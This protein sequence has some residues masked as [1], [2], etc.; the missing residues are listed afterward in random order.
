MKGVFRRYIA[1]YADSHQSVLNCAMHFIGIPTLFVAVLIP[2]GLYPVNIGP[3][4]IS[5]GSLM[6]VPAAIGWIALEWRI[7]AAMLV[8]VVPLAASAEWIA[9]SGSPGRAWWV[10]TLMF[11]VGWTFQIVGHAVFEGR[12]PALVGNLFHMFIGPMF[13][14]AKILVALGWWRD[15][16]ALLQ[17]S[18]SAGVAGTRSSEWSGS[19]A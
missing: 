19:R 5:I 11:A 3:I 14:T 4:A 10:A 18:S 17:G 1:A 15:L 6:V 12:K 16:A 7:G 8:A 2:L 9:R 13:V